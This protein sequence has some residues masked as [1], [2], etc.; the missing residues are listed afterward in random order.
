MWSDRGGAAAGLS[1]N[2]PEPFRYRQSGPGGGNGSSL[3]TDTA[4]EDSE[5]PTVQSQNLQRQAF[6]KGRQQGESQARAAAQNE[7]VA[8]RDKIRGAIEKFKDERAVYFSHIETDVVHLALAIARKI[9]HREAQID[10]LLLTG[11]V[12]VALEKLDT[13]SRVRMRA[14][15]ADIRSWSDFFLQ[16]GSHKSQPE[17]I[18]DLGLQRGECSLETESG[19]TQISL[20]GQLKEIEQGFLDLLE[21][22]PR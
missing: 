13:G 17:L 20:D 4:I 11:M 1:T 5:D 16:Q 2:V 9:L 12:H 22:R 15:P 19:S 21:Q 18:G 3:Q 8:E 6:E 10:P 14:H 7:T